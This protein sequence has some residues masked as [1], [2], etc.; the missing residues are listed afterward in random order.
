MLFVQKY[1][2]LKNTKITFEVEGIGFSSDS[3]DSPLWFLTYEKDET[4][5]Q[6]GGIYTDSEATKTTLEVN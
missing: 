2:F 6:N 3:T 1:D 4:N 5:I